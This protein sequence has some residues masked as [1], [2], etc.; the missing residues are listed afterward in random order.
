MV[1]GLSAAEGEGRVQEKFF[2]HNREGHRQGGHP[3]HRGA[4]LSGEGFFK[5]QIDHARKEVEDGNL[6][7]IVLRVNSP[8]GTITGSDYMLH[9]LRKFRE[10]TKAFRSWSAWAAWRPAAAT[11]CRWPSATRRASIFAEPTTWTGSIGVIIPHYNFAELM[12]RYGVEEDAIASH[13]SEEHGQHRPADDRRGERKIFKALV[14]DGFERF[15]DDHQRRP[16]EVQARP[17]ARSTNW[18]P[19]RSS[20]PSRP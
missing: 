12:K 7:A 16:A 8:G 15:K 3:L 6:K 11:T 9:H 2:S 20:P 1:L 4:I 14:D 19:A 5:Q 18:P 13:R 17:R 10:D